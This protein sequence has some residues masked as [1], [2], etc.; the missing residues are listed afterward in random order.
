M[1]FCFAVLIL[2]LVAIAN[3]QDAE[4]SGALTQDEILDIIKE[5][6]PTLSCINWECRTTCHSS[7]HRSGYC[8][9]GT[10]NCVGLLTAENEGL[11]K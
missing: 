11:T 6:N 2:G 5:S 9:L 4:N 7:G 10:C 1:K 3:C 8:A